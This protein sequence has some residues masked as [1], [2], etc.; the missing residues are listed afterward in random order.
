[1][2]KLLFELVYYCEFGKIDHVSV[3]AFGELSTGMECG[4][5]ES[6]VICLL[7]ISDRP[8]L[9]AYLYTM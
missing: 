2:W 3:K 6:L 1:M 8:I 4:I 5:L 9:I 7:N